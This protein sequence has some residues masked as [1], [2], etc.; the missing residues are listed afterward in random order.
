MNTNF[1]KQLKNHPVYNFV[2]TMKTQKNKL[3]LAGALLLSFIIKAQ[4]PCTVAPSSDKNYVTTEV[5]QK[6]EKVESNL[7]A[8]KAPD[9]MTTVQYLDG[10][11]RPLQTI[12]V[13]ASPTLKDNVSFNVYDLV[14]RESKVYLPYTSSGCGTYISTPITPQGTFYSSTANIETTTSPFAETAFEPSPLNRVTT[15]GAA[16]TDWQLANGHTQKFEY[17][18]NAYQEVRNYVMG[19]V[20]TLYYAAN[21]LVQKITKDENWVLTDLKNGTTEE[22]TDIEGHLILSRKYTDN[23]TFDTYYV[24]DA[25]G[26]LT[27]VVPPAARAVLVTGPSAATVLDKLCYQYQYDD[28]NR[29]TKKK[30]PGKDWEYTA[31]DQ[32]DRPVFTQDGNLRLQNKWLFTKYDAFGKVA[33]TGI[34]NSAETLETLQAM[35]NEKHSA[36]LV[37]SGTKYPLY[38]TRI[39]TP[40]TIDGKDIYYTNT[41]LPIIN[42]QLLTI[43]YYDNY[44]FDL[45][46]LTV[47]GSVYGATVS[48]PSSGML[49]GMLTGIKACV[50]ENV[51]TNT[52]NTNLNAHDNRARTIFANTQNRYT[53]YTQQNEFQLD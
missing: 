18:T 52:W 6:E 34:Y 2:S 4:T 51:L 11:G 3:V 31:Y 13:N 42:T 10:L 48:T 30:F 25:F 37:P 29:I 28:E 8:L 45:D 50:M 53:G 38:E 40:I 32:L 16:G 1:K 27:Y 9:K 17:G 7:T 35:L 44:A 36:A 46:G 26:N 23:K 19:N 5:L 24:Y 21:T 14:G 43:N 33:Y 47:P 41:A 39:T 49:T 15:Q 22:F 20:N 12:A